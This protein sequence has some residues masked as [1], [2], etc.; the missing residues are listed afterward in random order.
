MRNPISNIRH[1][2]GCPSKP[3]LVPP[4]AFLWLKLLKKINFSAG[5][6][7]DLTDTAGFQRSLV[8]V[9]DA[10]KR[11]WMFGHVGASVLKTTICV[12]A[13]NNFS[14]RSRE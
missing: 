2:T 11:D 3:N 4:K 6:Y 7:P 13:E 12:R 1:V 9:E 14:Q 8:A 5:F 10:M